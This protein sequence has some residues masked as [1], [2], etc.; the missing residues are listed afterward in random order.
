M[1]IVH[2]LNSLNPIY[3]GPTTSV[4][5]QCLGIRKLGVEIDEQYNASDSELDF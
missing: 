2:F 5:V 3:G 4:P 1:K